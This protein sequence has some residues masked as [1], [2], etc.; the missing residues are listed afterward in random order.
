MTVT[1]YT[2]LSQTGLSDRFQPEEFQKMES[3]EKV[4]PFV[5]NEYYLSLMNPD[6]PADPI[7]KIILPDPRELAHKGSLDPSAEESYTVLPGLQHKYPQTALLLVNNACAGICRYCF[8]KRLFIGDSPPP[9]CNICKAADYLQEKPEVTN[10]LLSGGDPLLLRPSELDTILSRLREVSNIPIHRIGSKALAYDPNR[11]V[12]NPDM[13]DVIRK[14]TEPGRQIYIV[15]HF[16][17]PVE[18][19]DTAEEAVTQLKQAGAEM[20]NQTPLISGVNDN[21]STLAT[22]F[23][24]LSVMGVPPYYVFQCRPTAGNRHLSI[25]IERGL[26]I[27]QGAQARCSGLAKRARYIMSHK[28]GKIEMVGRTPKHL[29][30]RYHQAA[31]PEDVGSMMVFRPNPEAYWLEDYQHRLTDMIPKMTWLF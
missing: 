27:F 29:Y 13:A 6:D 26:Q 23:Q 17:H 12:R 28:S 3:V 21:P 15:N 8:R 11:I 2:Q 31:R 18:I 24:R 9:T 16:D 5:A 7:R 10:V 4:Y 20:I 30:M 19:T 22:L 14:H 25:P 1:Y